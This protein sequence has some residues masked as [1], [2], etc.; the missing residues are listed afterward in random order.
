MT[1]LHRITG[2]LPYM[3]VVFL[4]AFVDLGH[5]IMVQNTVFKMYDGSEQVVLTAIVNS[6]ILLPYILLMTPA[7]FLSDKFAKTRVLQLSAAAAIGITLLIT[8]CY[9]MGWFWPAFGLTFLLAVQSAFYSPAKFGYIKE[10]VGKEQLGRG[11]GAI[12]AISIIGILGGTIFF[13]VLFDGRLDGQG[14]SSEGDILRLIAPLGWALVALSIV[15]YLLCLRL[16]TVER[17][18]RDMVFQWADY[19]RGKMLKSTVH[20]ITHRRVIWRSIVGLAIFWCIGQV[21]VAAFPA[22]AK[23]QMGVTKT[24]LIQGAV[25]CS[26][27]GIM[28]GSLIA[29]RASRSYI[30]TGTLPVGALIMAI[31]LL[32]IPGLESITG[33]MIN[34]VILG[35]GGGFVVVP[36]NSLVQFHADKHELGRILAG[37]NWVQNIGMLAVL[38]IT[39]LVSAAG[40]GTETLFYFVALVACG[41]VVWTLC[42][43]PQA[44]ARYVAALI[45]GRRYKLRVQGLTNLPGRGGVL[46]LGNHISWI[47]WAIVQIASPRPVRFVMYKDFYQRWYLKWFLDL[48]GAIPIG[49]S[50]TKAAMKRITE[51]LNQGEVV[52]LFPEGV[53]SRTGN[54][55][56]FQRGFETAAADTN[57][58]IVPFYLR[59]LWG[60][61][62]SRSSDRL[63]AMT[64]RGLLRD[65]MV[66]FG[67]PLPSDTTAEALKRKVFDLSIHSWDSYTK[68]LCS[69]PNSWIDT[70]KRNG[71]EMCAADS[72]GA[73]LSN[74]RMLAAAIAFSRRIKRQAKE[75]NV[76]FLLPSTSGTAIANMAALLLGKTLVNINFT[77][78]VQAQKAALQKAGVNTV[79]SSRKFVAKLRSKGVDLDPL[80]ADVQ[81]HYLEDMKEGIGKQEFVGW[82]LLVVLLPGR[83]LKRLFCARRDVD[84][85]AAILFSSGSEGTPKGVVLSHRNIL[86]NVKQMT[87]VLNVEDGD[88]IMGTL[89]PFHAFGL[90]VTQFL[91][92]IEGL[93]VV[94]H[95]DPTDAV[96]I[97]KAI[98]RYR[99]TIFCGTATFLRLYTCNNRVKPL[100]LESLRLVVAGAEKLSP[101]VREAFKLKFNKEIYEGYGATETSPVASVNVPDRL[102][103][104]DFRVQL[105]SKAG[106]VGMPLPGTSFRVVDPQTLE[107]LPAGEQGLVLVGGG[108]VMLGY[109]D[110]PEKTAE[111]LAEID[112][113]R[114]YKTGDK[115][116]IDSDGFLTIV[117]RYSRFA[118][119]GGEMVSLGA[120]EQAVRE[121]LRQPELEL[122]AVNLPDAKKG[123]RVVLLIAGEYQASNVR[124]SLL[125]AGI[126]SLMMPAKIYP[127]AEVPKL[128]SGKTDFAAAKALAVALEADSE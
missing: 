115:G 80:L 106:T 110:E 127:V 69:L 77:A 38:I 82:L 24:A 73:S 94:F 79:Y 119:L 62:F 116:H 54:L 57:S 7:G 67:K 72:T 23:E 25:A 9:Y 6:L 49:G 68:S 99:A 117:D 27:I 58:V 3:V 128:G 10:L 102:D 71:S 86:T 8:L 111:A 93:P 87:E 5:K 83:L 50:S 123:E 34:F 20:T 39:A 114:W 47:D 60:S 70:V 66:A 92:L 91:P 12:Q 81:V 16:P 107:I 2:F 28:L 17:G 126:N 97:G 42:K 41:G 55:A 108:Q 26:G 19:R 1:A 105:G 103:P 95:P 59:G 88:V 85:P 21:L 125:D 121:A 100:M 104:N 18:K 4:N 29:G 78:P 124:Q 37:N 22:F 90:S 30:E 52:C 11:N 43:L 109:L 63:A 33:A 98:A 61:R 32:R 76:G 96:N 45:I 14:F 56:E 44:F 36:L 46:L 13:S 112:G 74:Y 35:I 40:A 75:Q 15:E 101:D 31:T 51:L 53:I 89:P 122:V 84:D 64:G 113:I 48:M 120:V 118:K 65:I